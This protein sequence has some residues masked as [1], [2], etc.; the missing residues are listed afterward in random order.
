ML[1]PS[2]ASAKDVT[3]TPSLFAVGTDI[4]QTNDGTTFSNA[5][6]YNLVKDA[7]TLKVG[8]KIIIASN[9][10]AISITQNNNN[11]AAAD[12]SIT[13]D[14]I[15]SP[16][17][18]VQ[19]LTLDKNDKG[20]YS[21]YDGTRGYL[22]AASSSSNNLKTQ[23]S[24]TDNAYAEITIDP[25]TGVAAVTFKG[26]NTRNKLKYN[27]S[28]K[29]FS[30][31]G[32]GQT[33]VYI[34]KL[35]DGPEKKEYTP[36]FQNMSMTVGDVSSI[37][38]G[39]EHP[40]N[41][42]FSVT[43]GDAV[44]VEGNSITAV[45]EGD[46]VISATW[47]EDNVWKAS[48][49][50][51]TFTVTVAP[52]PTEPQT[53]TPTFA[54][55]NYIMT[56]G[57]APK[58]L[59][60]GTRHPVFN[61]TYTPEGIV[62]VDAEGNLSALKA[63]AA[64]VTVTWT[65]DEDW[66]G[67]EASFKATVNKKVYT[68]VF[69]ETYSVKEGS[70][71]QLNP[72]ENAP[73]II[74]I[75]NDD[76]V[77]TVSDSG[78]VTGLKAGSTLVTAMW[79]DDIWATGEA[80]FTITVEEVV[81]VEYTLVTA[82]DFT[83]LKDGEKVIIVANGATYSKAMGPRGVNDKGELKNNRTAIDVTIADNKI[84]NPDSK[85]EIL[86]FGILD[87]GKYSLKASDGFLSTNSK[88][89]NEL[90]TEETIQNGKATITIN[91][92]NN[93]AEI[94]FADTESKTTRNILRYNKA[95]NGNIF[96]CYSQAQEPVY[97]YKQVSVGPEE[98]VIYAPVADPAEGTFEESVDVTLSFAEANSDLDTNRYYIGYTT[99]GEV[100]EAIN[101]WEMY[102]PGNDEAI[103]LTRELNGNN[104][105]IKAVVIDSEILELVSEVATFSYTL[106]EKPVITPIEAADI[107]QALEKGENNFIVDE[108]G[109]L[110]VS[111][112]NFVIKS[113]LHVYAVDGASVYVTDNVNGGKG[114]RID[115][116]PSDMDTDKV[117]VNVMVKYVH[118]KVTGVKSFR[119][120]NHEEDSNSAA[121]EATE[122]ELTA[123]YGHEADYLHHHI[124][125]KSVYY[126]GEAGTISL[127]APAAEMMSRAPA[128]HAYVINV[129]KTVLGSAYGYADVWGYVKHDGTQPVFTAL[130]LGEIQ[131]GINGVQTD[132]GVTVVNGEIVAPEGSEVF[133]VN[134]MRV[135]VSGRQAPGIYVVRLSDGQA[136]KVVV[137]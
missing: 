58:S 53:Y 63:G 57:D 45:R 133:T 112:S 10:K 105:V 73:K 136:V 127:P 34:Y 47:A 5:A 120:V 98:S 125:L 72:G 40:D 8:D 99:N 76:A 116:V 128:D 79:G 110:E 54:G 129:D 50:P 35:V 130:R 117:L 24:P 65:G 126:D 115:D 39:E 83:N 59:E 74:F 28:N 3:V 19:I 114:T 132:G 91:S 17:S 80:E 135:A 88:D 97:L 29:L 134:G 55:Q 36:D 102:V 69:S 14:C 113:G 121:P 32:S 23:S 25:T 101:D 6:T 111:T 75:V 21:F 13:D 7:T 2:L 46:A 67:G 16:G 41:V 38:L 30:C 22:Y 107:A 122:L 124:K 131:T 43:S 15:V 93:Q 81:N 27:A 11:R 52:K 82:E 4:V 95:A 64:D 51:V 119:Y 103:T 49:E 92:S 123:F 87:G 100:S 1:L 70:T 106:T 61:Y 20:Y 68:S 26:S 71:L 62:S 60:F 37:D 90:V 42:V 104:P 9:N 96:A 12:V 118:N 137:K 66:I 44:T 78:L 31:Y 85:V 94:Q 18:D 84:V 33:D 56:I 48:T 77:A 89:K 86:I 109:D 108:E